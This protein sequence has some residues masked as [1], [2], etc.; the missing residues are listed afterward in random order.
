MIYTILISIVF[1]AELIIALTF[2]I[3]ILKLNKAVIKTNEDFVKIQPTLKDIFVLYRKISEQI[4]TLSQEYVHKIQVNSEDAILRKI[5]KL[6][7]AFLVFK[8]NFKIINRIK[9]SKITKYLS[10]GLSLLETM[11]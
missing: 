9:K 1:I 5:S 7:M 8:L 10:K 4:K 2:I 11:V 6:L 3:N